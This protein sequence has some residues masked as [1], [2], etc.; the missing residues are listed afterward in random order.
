VP[1]SRE[2]HVAHR[3]LGRIDDALLLFGG[4]YSNLQATEALLGEAHRRRIPGARMICTGDVVAYGGDP[5]ATV[6]AIRASGCAVVAGNCERQLA[7]RAETCGCGFEDGSACDLLSAG[8]YGFAREHIGVQERTW[9]AGCPDVASFSHH[10]ARYAVIHGGISDIARF[11]WPVSPET[12][13]LEEWA[14]VEA[15]IGPV[16]HVIAG[17]CGIPFLRRTSRGQ[18]INPGVIGMPPH[19]GA[20]QTRFA[21]LDAGEVVIEELTYDAEAAHAAMLRA[22]LAQGY[23]EALLSGHWPSEDV[24]PEAL[25]LPSFARG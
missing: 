7:E 25:R 17:H 3:D 1:Q 13:F 15:A 22:G 21:V 14:C 11:L 5:V 18:W 20:R 2:E 10:G 12:A 16:D 19:D 23:H 4:P 6:A 9:M 8:W 24:L